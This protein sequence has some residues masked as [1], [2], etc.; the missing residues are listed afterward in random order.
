MICDHFLLS[1]AYEAVQGLSE[2]F[3][4]RFLNDDV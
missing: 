2:W 1:S 4:M 3:N